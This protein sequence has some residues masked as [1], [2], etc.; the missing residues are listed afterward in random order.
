MLKQLL[1]HKQAAPEQLTNTGTSDLT[2]RA[3][4]MRGSSAA[5][6][7]G[8]RTLLSRSSAG[9][10]SAENVTLS[11]SAAGK[12]TVGRDLVVAGGAVGLVQAADDATIEHGYVGALISGQ[13]HVENGVV[14]LVVGRD[15]T[16]SPGVRVLI[17]A[18]EALLLLVGLAVLLPLVRALLRRVMPP[19]P[20]PA[21]DDRPL[22]VR[23][24]RAALGFGLRIGIVAGL[25]F[26]AYR[27]VRRRIEAFIP[28]AL[29]R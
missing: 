17:G 26:L 3:V 11:L 13:A 5:Q 22:L 10:I 15:V 7:H 21:D 29:R 2:S 4:T 23:V 20:P 1:R 18:R 12:A 28:A 8:E 9:Q 6:I 24:G 25:G 27:T 14:G 16:I 19:P